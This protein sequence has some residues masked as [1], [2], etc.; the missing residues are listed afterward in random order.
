M[1][2][3]KL[4]SFF[5]AGMCVV[6]ALS[7]FVVFAESAD[8]QALIRKLTADVAALQA[9]I[10]GLR[11]TG[12]SG[13]GGSALSS[14]A[15]ASPTPLPAP[16]TGFSAPNTA[17]SVPGASSAPSPVPEGTVADKNVQ[18][19]PRSALSAPTGGESGDEGPQAAISFDHDLYM[20]LR[21]DPDVSNL[22][23]FLTD[24]GFYNQTISGNFFILT[25]NAVKKF[26]QAHDLKPTG[27]FGPLSRAVANK[28]LAGGAGAEANRLPPARAANK[29]SFS[30]DPSSVLLS[31]GETAKVRAI[32]TPPY[33]ACLDA[34][35][36]CAIPT[37]APYEVDAALISGD[38]SVAR[39][40]CAPE[41]ARLTCVGS[42]GVSGVSPGVATMSATYANGAD[43][44]TAQMT[45]RVVSASE[46][47]GFLYLDPS[48]AR[49]KAGE[50]V[51]IQAFFR[52]PC[53]T[54]SAPCVR[55]I[56]SVNAAFASDMPSVAAVDQ[57][58]TKDPC[59]PPRMCPV[60]LNTTAAIRG[61][62]SGEA[63]ITAS[64]TDNQVP[65]SAKMRVAVVAP[66]PVIS[67]CAKEPAD[68]Q[69][70]CWQNAAQQ[71]G[72]ISLCGN[73]TVPNVL[74]SKDSCISA[75]AQTKKDSALCASIA[76]AAARQACVSGIASGGFLPFPT[77]HAS[78]TP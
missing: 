11:K 74:F 21:N 70:R 47:S 18:A 41:A 3:K 52:A 60:A 37:R 56:Q 24:Q 16:L 32:F 61:V 1:H 69:N 9:Q 66:S 77:I 71:N 75:V 38:P 46:G 65:Y 51:A 35:P 34:T 28:I 30:L 59:A 10:D 42:N 54:G 67:N 12:A 62:S 43:S 39:T 48:S 53:P 76:N 31:V 63:I 33:P 23:E 2:T 72:D 6:T 8:Q 55:S 4:N 50:T 78:S 29:G 20:G 14:S 5:V 58:I 7:P 36:P 26:Q 44:F 25:R 45:V 17:M 15:T 49:L 27:Y 19:L 73:I 22:Q 57:P 40:T 64:Y 68:S 13:P